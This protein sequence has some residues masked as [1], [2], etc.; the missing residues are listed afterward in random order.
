MCKCCGSGAGA[1]MGQGGELF[2]RV[3][4]TTVTGL[5]IAMRAIRIIRELRGITSFRVISE[6]Y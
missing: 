1:G 3:T 6:C 2:I 5:I 4:A